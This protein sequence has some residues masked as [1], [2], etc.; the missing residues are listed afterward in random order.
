M[1]SIAVA[2]CIS[3]IGT[4][5]QALQI[6]KVLSAAGAS[7]CYLESNRNEYLKN[8]TNLYVCADELKDRVEYNGIVMYKR[9]HSKA[10]VG[11]GYDYII[12]D[13]GNINSGNFEE[14]SFAEQ[15]T[16]IVVCG[17]KPNEIFK[18]QSILSNPIYDDAYFIFSFVPENER[19][20]VVSMMSQRAKQT[21]FAEIVMD[22][23]NESK[24]SKDLVRRILQLDIK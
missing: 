14:S 10:A 13:Y 8:L 6:V 20:S 2:G 1:E 19:V 16:K 11:S 18:M 24:Y 22:P 5:T 15:A 23:F 9:N 7:V 21:L 3:H 17:S 12:K 4:T